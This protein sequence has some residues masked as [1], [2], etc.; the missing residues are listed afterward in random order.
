MSSVEEARNPV[1]LG[2]KPLTL[3]HMQ[4]APLEPDTLESA[5]RMENLTISGTSRRAVLTDYPC[6]Q[7]KK[8]ETRWFLG[9]TKKSV[10]NADQVRLVPESVRTALT[11]GLDAPRG[12]SRSFPCL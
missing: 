1:V 9:G 11:P 3:I 4:T 5:A 6:P 7:L 8:Q 12:D 2:R 10:A